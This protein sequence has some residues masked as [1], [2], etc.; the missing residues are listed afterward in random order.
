MA[1]ITISRQLGSAGDYIAGLI[2]STLSYKL[3]NKQSIVIEMRKRGTIDQEIIDRIGEGKPSFLERFHRKMSHAV[4]EMRSILRDAASEGD[5]VIVGRCGNIELKDRTDL[6]KVRVI[7]H[8]ETRISR[9]QQ[10]NNIERLQAVN[11]IKNSDRERSGYAKHFF[12]VDS[13]AP[14]LYDIVINTT[15]I[16]PDVAARLIEQTARRFSGY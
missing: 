16:Q 2:A 12:F 4:Y 7:A 10:E 3:V 8:I 11:M 5:V 9:I 1:V 6:L 14:E 13:S 15:R